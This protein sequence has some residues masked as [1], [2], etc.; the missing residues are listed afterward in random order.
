MIYP[1]I[2]P[3]ISGNS[4]PKSFL[5]TSPREGGHHGGGGAQQSPR[6]GL[7]QGGSLEVTLV[8]QKA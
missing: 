8:I 2:N 1:T 4:S 5:L 3:P 7:D 6:F